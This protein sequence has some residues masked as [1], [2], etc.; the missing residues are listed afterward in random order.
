MKPDIAFAAPRL[1]FIVAAIIVLMLVACTRGPYW[2]ATL[3]PAP[4]SGVIEIANTTGVCRGPSIGCYD[5]M[6]GQIWIQAGMEPNLR[7]CV[8]SHEYHHAAGYTHKIME[9]GYGV[10]C[11]DGTVM[12]GAI[13]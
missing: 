6:T 2:E 10:D 4:V 9:P 8:I 1:A 11:G 7:L 3:P 13:A 5:R 12:P